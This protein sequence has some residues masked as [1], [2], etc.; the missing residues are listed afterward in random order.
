MIGFRCTTNALNI[1]QSF[2][3]NIGIGG[4]GGNI[5]SIGSS[6]SD[7]KL[8]QSINVGTTSS[9]NISAYVY[10]NTTGNV[11]G[12]I[13]TSIASLWYNGS[14]IGTTYTNVS[15]TKGA[16]WWKLSGTL[17]GANT[18]RDYGILVKAGKTV[19]V[20]DFTLST[21]QPYSIYTTTAYS[22]S[23]INKW[24]SLCEGT[25]SGS[26][27]TVTST[28][29]DGNSITY[30]ICQDNGS[31]C[32]TN[33]S[34][35]YWDGDSW[36]TAIDATTS[37]TAAQLTQTAMQA[38]NTISSKRISIKAFLNFTIEGSQSQSNLPKLPNITIGFT[39]D[40]AAPLTQASAVKLKF[41]STATTEYSHNSENPVW[42]K[43]ENPY[44]SWSE[45]GDEEG[46]TGIKGYCLYL[47]QDE[48]AVPNQAGNLLNTDNSPIST[49]DTNPSCRFIVSNNFVNFSLTN[50]RG[51]T[52]LESSSD[53]YYLKVWAVDNASNVQP[54]NPAV[55]AFRFDNTDP[56]NVSFISPASGNFSNVVDMNFSWPT[57]VNG[58]STDNNSEL[59]G[60]QYQ[61]NSTDGEW[62]GTTTSP[63]LG[64][65]YIPVGVSTYNL[66]QTRDGSS[67]ITGNNVIY[68]RSVDKVG[69]VS[70][71]L[72]IRTGNIS[73]GGA[74]PSFPNTSKVTVNPVSSDTNSFALSWDEATPTVGKLV[75]K[76]FY[77]INTPP[78]ATYAT[79]IGNP[80]VYL[81]VGS[82]NSVAAN[83]LVGVNKGSNT[84]YVVAVDNA[85]TPNYSPS[86]Y[87]S[88]TFTLNS[89]N[90]DNVSNLTSSDSSI[91]SL[92][93]WNVTLTWKAPIYQGAGNLTYLVYRSSDGINFAQS[94]ST[95]GLSYVDNT[96]LSK[97]YYYRIYVKDGANALSSG[98]N[99]VLITPT[100]KW[101]S[102]PTLES[103]PSVNN[104]TTRKATITWATNRTSDSKI[105]YGTASG[106]YGDVEPSNS[107]QVSSHSVQLTGLTAGTTYYFKTKWTDEDGNLGVSDEENFITQAA[108]TVKDVAAKNVGLSSSIIQLTVN[109][110]SR[111]KVYYGK[112]T[113]FGGIKEIATS[114]DETTYTIELSGLEDGTK[115]YYKINLFDSEGS[116]Y[117]G[118]ILDFSTLPRPKISEVR[119]EQVANTAQT[120][121]KVSWKTNTEVSSIATYYPENNSSGSRDEI[122]IAL[123]KGEHSLMIRGLLPQTNYILIVKGRDKLGNEA[124][125]ENQRFTTA[126]DTRQPSILNLKVQGGTIPPVGFA[127]G[128]VKAQLIIT[129]DTDE[130]ATSQVE[131]GEGTGTNYGQKSQEDGNLTNN[132]TVI[133]SNLTP[134]KVY[135]LRTISKDSVG[136]ESKSVDTVTIAPKATKSAIDLVIKNLSEALN[137]ANIIQLP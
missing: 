90:P 123:E 134:S 16:G 61:I 130:P 10:D 25:L 21:K 45:G 54:N 100:G 113:S 34:W 3:P 63:D 97:L 118:T 131:F 120:T 126:T 24:D 1:G 38:L 106:V 76:Y 42:T 75:S 67:I 125:S 122:K 48:S 109:R 19:K 77:M 93:Q 89:T 103:E 112:S 136:N 129:W 47:G 124:I 33:S 81:D 119:L 88:G 13:G 65:K 32:E 99:S 70:S 115:Y 86:N 41:N 127:A 43:E 69:N 59:L 71:D 83:S 96:P 4:S 2:V 114:T 50:L 20:D 121:I 133:L 27:C 95:S 104:I 40:T 58:A 26:D 28:N 116:E 22:N 102:P 37:N 55:M 111:A 80:S 64:I 44:F 91:K 9:Y 62:L 29:P 57:D 73:Y 68:F 85:Q 128:E 82:S 110:A 137:F 8:V 39:T 117:E 17:T 87:I 23:Q 51:S 101:T 53:P 60:W 72:T 14:A 78:P 98:T 12:D 49:V 11:G 5:I 35:K 94:G 66:N 36:E 132:H 79:L 30:Q 74:A 15:S 135:H 31:L 52:W 56:T 105:Q 84:V 92:S 6:I 107:S 7:A 108:P 46:G 18:S